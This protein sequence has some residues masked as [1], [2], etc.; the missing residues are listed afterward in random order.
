MHADR[1]FDAP[2]SLWDPS[3]RRKEADPQQQLAPH[4]QSL[5]Q[6]LELNA[7]LHAMAEGDE[8]LF[9]VARKALLSGLRNDV[10]TIVY[11]QNI[12]KDCLN[13]TAS[14]R[15]LYNLS[16]EATE[17]K[18]QWWGLSSQYPSSVL[19][20]SIEQLEFLLGMLR[21]LRGIAEDHAS[22]FQSE[23]FTTLF[24]MIR[25]E[26]DDEYLARIQ[27][28]LTE[29][30]FRK[31]VLLSSE[32][33]E[34]NESSSLV[35]RKT[36]QNNQ[37]W[38]QR[39]FGNGE[40]G[41]TFRLAERDE[42]GAQILSD[43]RNRGIARVV[44]ALAQSAEH[45]LNFFK[46]LRTELAFYI[47]CLNL[48][49][50]LTAKGEPSCFPMPIAAGERQ[51]NFRGLYDVCLSLHMDSR[52]AGNA[53]VADGKSLIIVTGA[54]QGG[55]STF[56]RS[57]GL[58]QLM[59]QCGMF[60]GAEAFEAEICPGLFTHYKREEDVTMQSGKLDEE[61]ARMS[62]IVDQIAPNAMLLFNESFAAT[63]EREGSEIADQIV[64]ALLEK[65]IKILYVTHLYQFARG[66]F[67]RRMENA[68]F[69]RAERNSD[70]TRT[71][72]VIE[73][74]PLETSYGDDLY[75]MVFPVEISA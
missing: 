50:R 47:G 41:Y 25:K 8:F 68:L 4:E 52:V 59:M 35:L 27:N 69:L 33:G 10:D 15:G 30:K 51:L 65:R 54:N 9:D 12:A 16:V 19:Y 60:V 7:L 13:S 63:N 38:L 58:A 57:A 37:N 74:E 46:V 67:E 66:Y 72:K 29:L 55:K 49:H 45:V 39:I 14:V 20:S 24:A 31:G 43:M 22:R 42:A 70:G 53:I 73:G 40:A 11:R 44:I 6:D 23:G 64:S 36:P 3:Y 21:K 32:L 61:L 34:W 26:L 48:H 71:F 28:H 75:R 17:R 56:L 2:V 5:V 1:D 18:G 62:E